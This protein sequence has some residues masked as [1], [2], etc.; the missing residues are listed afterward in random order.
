MIGELAAL[1]TA[2]IWSIGSLFFTSAGRCLGA[3]NVNR[4]RLIFGVLLLGTTLLLTKGWLLPPGIEDENL[5]YLALS[6][7]I[8]LVIGDSFL[9][10][11]M[12]ILGT[13][14]TMLI[15]ALSPAIAAITAFA[16]IGESLDIL[17]IVGITVTLVGVI[18]VTSEQRFD[19]NNGAVKVSPKGILFAFLGGSGQAIGIVF[20]KMG[21]ADSV[22]PLAGTFL[23]MVF[24]AGTIWIVS[25]FTGS[26]IRT[27]KSLKNQ[28]GLLLTF[29][30]AVFGP[31]LGVWMS[32]V[33]VKNTE[34]GVAMAITSIV[35]VLVIPWV[36]LFY[37][38]KVSPRAFIGALVAVLGVFIL[39]IH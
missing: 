17:S 16:F 25:L 19:S 10:S 22:D 35:P 7:I 39:F 2:F 32:L 6:G 21:M 1:T 26:F 30:G 3:L 11:A 34:A 29:G 8:G 27:I 37:K 15:Y 31:F 36:I 23:R 24:A 13:R 12:V 38:E 33:A 4:I 20:A 18:W 28:K 5:I 14:L 9:F